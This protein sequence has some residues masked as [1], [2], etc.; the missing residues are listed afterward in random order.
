M[1]SHCKASSQ[2][3]PSAKPAT[4]AIT[5]LRASRDAVPVRREIVEEDVGERL[6]RHFLDV[7]ARGE[8]LVRAGDD[9]AAD[10]AVGLE[11]IDGVGKFAHQRGVERVER[12]RPI[13][14]DQADPA[15]GFDD[16]VCR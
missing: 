8:G 9:D 2:P 3:P 6:V 16:D 1:M 13:E 7:G 4:A 10:I 11:A 14:P 12:L 5:G 15:A